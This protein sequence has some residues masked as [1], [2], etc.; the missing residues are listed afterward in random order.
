[1]LYRKF[2]DTILGYISDPQL[3]EEI[4][5]Y[6]TATVR[7]KYEAGE[8]TK[9]TLIKQEQR[10]RQD[11]EDVREDIVNKFDSRGRRYHKCAILVITSIII[12]YFFSLGLLQVIGIS[13]SLL[14][15]IIL[16]LGVIRGIYWTYGLFLV[17]FHGSTGR[18]YRKE[19]LNNTVDGVYG[20]IFII[21]GFTIQLASVIIKT[22]N[23]GRIPFL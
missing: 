11:I 9:E 18:Y 7:D 21:F 10:H 12:D 17:T 3:E 15:S 1:M 8:I 22:Y 16:S 5:H 2:V 19:T 20:V 6:L 13:T 4:V 23:F 14:G